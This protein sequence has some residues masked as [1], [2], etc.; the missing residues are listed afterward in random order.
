METWQLS[1]IVFAALT[2]LLLAGVP[3]AFALLALGAAG[4]LYVWGPKGLLMLFNTAYGEGT[5]YILL[6]VPLFVLMANVLK[7]S[8]K[9]GRA[10]V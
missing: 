10:H 7:F 2:A 6:A 1:L 4:T 5:S 3:I 9:I 8:G